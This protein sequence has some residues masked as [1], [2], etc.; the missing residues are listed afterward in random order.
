MSTEIGTFDPRRKPLDHRQDAAAFLRRIEWLRARPRRFAA[1]IQQ[2]GPVR[3]HLNA[4]LD[5]ARRIEQHAAV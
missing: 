2:V 3:H 1:D 5:G 4:S